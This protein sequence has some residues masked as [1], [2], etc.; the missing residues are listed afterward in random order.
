[1]SEVSVIG[2]D[3]AKRVFQ[4]HGADASGRVGVRKQLR[5][6][7]VRSSLAGSPGAWWRWRRVGART[8]DTVGHSTG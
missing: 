2:L 3:L 1:M 7:P 6:S 4:I 5:R 8:S